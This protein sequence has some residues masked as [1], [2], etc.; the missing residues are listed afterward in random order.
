[1]LQEK[2]KGV[3]REKTKPKTVFQKGRNRQAASQEGG[4]GGK[5]E[6]MEERECT[7]LFSFEKVVGKGS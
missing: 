6:R 5:K 7:T 3:G 2:G 1:M 4:G